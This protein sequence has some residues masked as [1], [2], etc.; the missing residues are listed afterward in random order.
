MPSCTSFC[1]MSM[2][3]RSTQAQRTL[4]TL[5]RIEKDIRCARD[6]TKLVKTYPLVNHDVAIGAN[7]TDVFVAE[8]TPAAIAARDELPEEQGRT[9]QRRS[10]DT[11]GETVS[12]LQREK[13]EVCFATRSA[14]NHSH[15][16]YF[17]R[18]FPSPVRT[19]CSIWWWPVF[20]ASLRK[21]SPFS[22]A[23]TLS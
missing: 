18:I 21:T 1:L 19:S 23:T 9:P 11:L 3:P 8:K 14:L 20:S 5:L 13:F 16:V 7:P 4:N 6:V 15:Q 12:E 22:N 10:A 2:S 17:F